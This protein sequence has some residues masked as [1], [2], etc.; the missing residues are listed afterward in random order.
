MRKILLFLLLVPFLIKGIEV[1]FSS[2]IVKTENNLISEFVRVGPPDAAPMELSTQAWLWH[3]KKNLFIMVESVFDENLETGKFADRDDSPGADFIRIQLITEDKN[4]YAYGF[5]AYPLGSKSDFVRNSQFES[6]YNWNSNYDY[7]TE[8]D[9][10]LWKVLFMIPFNDLRYSADPPY[11]WKIIISRYHKKSRQTFSNKFL[12]AEMG[13]DYFREAETISINSEIISAKTFRIKPYG[14]FNYDILNDKTEFDETNIGLDISYNP[15]PTLRSKLSISPDFSD[16]PLDT[17]TDTYNSKYAPSFSENRYFFIEDFNAFGTDKNLFYSRNIVQPIYAFKFSGKVNN[18]DFGILSARDKLIETESNGQTFV[19][20]PDDFYNII[21]FKPVW[22]NFRCQFT[23]LNRSNDDYQNTVLHTY[24]I[25]EAGKNKYIWA[26]V[27]LSS[28]E[29]NENSN[30]G[31]HLMAGYSVYN[32]IRVINF[33]VQQMSRDYAIDMGTIYEDDFYG[34]NLDLKSVHETDFAI[35][36]EISHSATFLEEIDNRSNLLLERLANMKMRFVTCYN[37][38]LEFDFIYVKENTAPS[39]AVASFTDKKRVGLRLEWD[40]LT[41]FI[42]RLGLNKV[43]YYFYSLEK[44]YPGYIVQYNAYGNLFKRLSYY[45]NIDYSVYQDIPKL[46]FVDKE[47]VL[48]NLDS[49][50]NFSNRASITAGVRFHNYAVYDYY[51][52][53]GFYSNF[54]WEINPKLNFFL[55]FNSEMNEIANEIVKDYAK[56]YSKLTY[57]F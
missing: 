12:L 17:V 9:Q 25:W 32:Q 6:D 46:S 49:T 21:A 10:N 51:L 56:F 14:I 57:I 13:N 4:Y 39:S 31:Y 1:P 38:D 33:S 36:D 19:S 23:L 54:K 16:I 2:Q 3:D 43:D 7:K 29:F 48:G 28:K 45:F 5:F 15:Y 35:I 44:N 8:I 30:F 50:Y 26:K 47:Y 34:W 24:P 18:F 20:N 55:G 42:N 52:Y 37:F 41:W 40:K 11:N 53:L 27:N 22:D